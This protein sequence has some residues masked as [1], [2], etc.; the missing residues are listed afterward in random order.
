MKLKNLIAEIERILPPDWALPNDPIG[1]HL[2]DPDQ[3]VKR[4]LVALE[5]SARLLK[6]TSRKNVDLLFV[7]HPLL[8]RP[9]KRIV[10]GDPVQSITR[11]LIKKDIA[12]YAAHTN[13]DLHPQGMAKLWAQKLGFVTASPLAPKPQAGLMKIITFVPAEHAAAVRQALSKAGAGRIGEYEQCSFTT[14]GVGTFFGSGDSVPYQ[15]QAG[16]L[17]QVDEDRIEMVFPVKRKIAVV[18][19][20]LQ[21]HP[22]DEAAYDLIA[23]ED[24]R[25]IS[26]AIWIAELKKP[27]SWRTF[28]ARLS[29]HAP[30][31]PVL[32]GVRPQPRK[33]IQRIAIMT[34]SGASGIPLA[35]SL[36]V[37]A[38]LTGEAGYHDLWNAN[39]V[40]LNVMTIGH[41]VSESI[42]AE[43]AIGL[44]KNRIKNVR[45]VSEYGN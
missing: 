44:L 2:G 37:D 26:Q 17:E 43:A 11:A 40:G 16:R 34:G 39:E 24:F 8:Y 45:W 25:D 5:A 10:E 13:M 35:A 23:L 38:Y 22:Y 12:L 42:F 32:G 1:L 31:P 19:A 9:L 18:R 27:I 15:G 30:I 41:D 7:H 4:V 33:R 21:S 28:E 14:P 20:L 3:D 36:N 29:K 6:K